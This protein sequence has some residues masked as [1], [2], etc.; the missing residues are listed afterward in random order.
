[1]NDLLLEIY[2][3]ELPSSAQIIGKNQLYQFFLELFSKKKINYS[4]IETFSTSRRI[5]II[6]KKIS[7]NEMILMMKKNL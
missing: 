5:S 2:G 1:M 3:E 7:K 6:I 4:S